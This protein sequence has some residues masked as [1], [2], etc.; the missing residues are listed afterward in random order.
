MK[1]DAILTIKLPA[2]GGRLEDFSVREPRRFDRPTRPF[3]RRALGAAHVVAD[4]WST[5]D[6][7]LEPA[8]D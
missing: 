4:P 7:W 5:R 3:T 6:P 8:I 2:A 1:R